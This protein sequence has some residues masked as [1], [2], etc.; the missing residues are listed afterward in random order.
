MWQCPQRHKVKEGEKY[1]HPRPLNYQ[2]IKK[3][4]IKFTCT[5]PRIVSA[6]NHVVETFTLQLLI[7]LFPEPTGSYLC[8]RVFP[9]STDI[10]VYRY[11]C[12]YTCM[13]TCDFIFVVSVYITVRNHSRVGSCHSWDTW[14]SALFPDS[15]RDSWHNLFHVG[16]LRYLRQWWGST[17]NWRGF[18]KY[19]CTNIVSKTPLYIQDTVRPHSNWV[20][21]VSANISSLQTSIYFVRWC[22]GPVG[23]SSSGPTYNSVYVRVFG[24]NPHIP[25]IHGVWVL[26]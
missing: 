16:T 18:G 7:T 17:W 24:L 4:I 10:D 1:D 21:E 12:I 26:S 19:A 3:T 5:N 25:P 6:G 11:W 2:N 8:Y 22:P 20:L 23:V 9:F 15:R 14:K 13:Y